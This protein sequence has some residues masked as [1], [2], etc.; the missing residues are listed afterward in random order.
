MKVS[1][2]AIKSEQG[3]ANQTPFNPQK[4]G[5][6]NSN[7]IRN[8]TCRESDKIMAFTAFPMDWKKLAAMIWNVT[9]GNAIRL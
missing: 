2:I 6:I 3:E 1:S 4:F 5:V 8:I 9:I 7:G